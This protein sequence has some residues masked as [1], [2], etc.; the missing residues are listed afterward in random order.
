MKTVR[1]VAIVLIGSMLLPMNAAIHAQP[2]SQPAGE[3]ASVEGLNRM[4]A[5]LEEAYNRGDVDGI[6]R[7][8]HPDAVIIFPDG[9]ILKGPEALRAY[10]QRMLAGPEP[11][12]KAYTANPVVES[13][14]VHGDV[15]LS[16]GRMND[17]YALTDGTEFSLDSR[18]TVTLIKSPNGPAD[19]EGWMIRSFHSST[20]AFDNPVLAIAAKRSAWVAGLGGAVVG[21]IVGLIVGLFIRR[22]R[23]NSAGLAQA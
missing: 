10:Y 5:S 21:L 14:T 17:S 18:F 20:D 3:E 16:Y 11:I 12:V 2:A 8:S 19:T 23:Q 7:Y 6:L 9:Q 15:G 22:R 4:R 1:A 13:R